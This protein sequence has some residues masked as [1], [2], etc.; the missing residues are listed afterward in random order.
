MEIFYDLNKDKWDLLHDDI[1]T[2]KKIQRGA[3]AFK[4]INETAE[5]MA[6]S[7]WLKNK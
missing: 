2:A 7:R 1:D 6:V 3:D 4:I 5:E